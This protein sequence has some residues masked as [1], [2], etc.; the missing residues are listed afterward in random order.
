[1]LILLATFA[2]SSLKQ[3]SLARKDILLASIEQGNLDITVEGYGTLKSNKKQLLTS[4]SNA[5][6]TNILLKPGAVVNKGSVIVQLTNP[7]LVQQVENALQELAQINANLR[8]LKVN[9]T[10][11]TLLEQ[12][13]FAQL[14]A[15]YQTAK[16][17]RAAEDELAQQ[18]IVS[19]FIY[20]TSKLDEAQ[21]KQRIN[22]FEQRVKQLVLVHQEAINI[23]QQRIKQQQGRLAIAQ[24]RVDKLSIKAGFAGVLQRLSVSLGQSL[25][26]GQEV[27]LIGSVKD[28]IALIKVPQNQAQQVQLGQVAV[29]DTRLAEIIGKVVRINPIVENNT[30]EIEIALPATLPKS[31][32]PEQNVDAKIIANTLNNVLYLTRPANVKAH[33]QLSLYKISDDLSKAVKTSIHT[34]FKAGRH[35][36]INQGAQ[37]GDRFIISDLSNYQV[38]EVA[39]N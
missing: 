22:L 10:R 8:Q 15:Q 25:T 27:A 21:L 19:Q 31:S 23:A 20:Q 12:S 6:V 28:L 9:Q 17:K 32:R 26:A 18:G 13:N 2:N 7:E 11:E 37:V 29:I 4:F 33:Q 35:I 16:L 5:T 3:V 38:H 1:M 34:G 14:K 36:E 30:V 24:Q 39:I